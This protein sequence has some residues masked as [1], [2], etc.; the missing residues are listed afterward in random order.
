M[1]NLPAR[2]GD[3][4]KHETEPRSPRK[5][6]E[7]ELPSEL[8]EAILQASNLIAAVLPP[9]IDLRLHFEDS[10][11]LY[12]TAPDLIAGA[13]AR[14]D[15]PAKINEGRL[16]VTLEVVGRR[17]WFSVDVATYGL[18]GASLEE[19]ITARGKLVADEH[20]YN[21]IWLEFLDTYYSRLS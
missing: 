4:E 6:R 2:R 10:S 15:V 21:D 11:D 1:T 8:R 17:G 3:P 19:T 9:G 18:G 14:S 16:E 20:G 7:Q 13:I 12:Y 5:A